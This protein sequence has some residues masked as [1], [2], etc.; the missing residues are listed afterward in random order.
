MNLSEEAFSEPTSFDHMPLVYFRFENPLKSDSPLPAVVDL[1]KLH[2][3]NES[4]EFS[5]DYRVALENINNRKF[6]MDLLFSIDED[7]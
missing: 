6:I 4:K 2:E 3:R 1:T 7:K 5:F